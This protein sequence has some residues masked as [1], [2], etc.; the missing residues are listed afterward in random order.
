V[1]RLMHVSDHLTL[2][3]ATPLVVLDNSTGACGPKAAD[4]EAGA[5]ARA[6][7]QC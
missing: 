3:G 6:S 5:V 7:T 2:C 4:E 1:S